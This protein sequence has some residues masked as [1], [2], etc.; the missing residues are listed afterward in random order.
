MVCKLSTITVAIL[1]AMSHANASEATTKATADLASRL[2]TNASKITVVSEKQTTWFDGSLGLRQPGRVYTKA[3]ESGS[4][5]ILQAQN[6]K[7]LYT[8]SKSTVKFGGPVDLWK[9]SLLYLAK[10]ENEPNLNDDLMACSLLG[11]NPR[12][13]LESVS[14][15]QVLENN[16]I[17]ALRR[18]SRSGF[19]LLL[20]KAGSSKPIKVDGGFAYGEFAGNGQVWVAY[21]RPR[22]GAEWEIVYGLFGTKEPKVAPM[23]PEG[24]PQR[25]V[26]VQ[27]EILAKTGEGWYALDTSAANPEWRTASAPLGLNES[28]LLLNRSESLIV[29]M[30][31]KDTYIATKFFTGILTEIARIPNLEL[32]SFEYLLGRYVVVSG[33]QNGKLAVYIVDRHTKAVFE[34]LSGDYRMPCVSGLATVPSV[35]LSGFLK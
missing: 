10:H 35:E 33:I 11:T 31:G 26:C 27:S 2:K 34:S 19:D 30:K 13:V 6:T 18:T 25:F 9:K 14:D 4:V 17:L 29:E 5:I 21:K 8:S 24:K 20:L 32:K 1:V 22:L 16:D 12:L 23:L 3:I 7:Y 15:Y 28:P